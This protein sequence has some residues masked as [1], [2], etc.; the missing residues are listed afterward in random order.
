MPGRLA[1]GLPTERG[2]LVSSG[3]GGM[4]AILTPGVIPPDNALGPGW[5]NR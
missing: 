2:R 5:W 4:R 1:K 3:G